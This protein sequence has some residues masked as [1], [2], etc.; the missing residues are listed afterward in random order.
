MIRRIGKNLAVYKGDPPDASVQLER[1]GYAVLRG[2]LTDD[3]V[4]ALVAEIEDAYDP[5]RDP[6]RGPA[7]S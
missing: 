4:A 7:R 2:V 1:D 3:E 5:A 6:Q